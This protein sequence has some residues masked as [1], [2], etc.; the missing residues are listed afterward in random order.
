MKPIE[1]GMVVK[2]I[3]CLSVLYAAQRTK[4]KAIAWDCSEPGLIFGLDSL[5]EASRFCAEKTDGDWRYEG[6]PFSE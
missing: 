2:R 5:D 4:C 1:C 6:R 3:A